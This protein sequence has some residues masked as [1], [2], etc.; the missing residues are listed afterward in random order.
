METAR[1]GGVAGCEVRDRKAGGDEDAGWKGTASFPREQMLNLSS[2]T[3]DERA[4]SPLVPVSMAA[5]RSI[6]C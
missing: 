2:L 4:N 3:N 1:E 6:Y 5:V